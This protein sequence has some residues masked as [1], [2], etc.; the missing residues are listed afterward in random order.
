MQDFVVL[1][2]GF[3]P[4]VDLTYLLIIVVLTFKISLS[5]ASR[6]LS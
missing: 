1:A 3:N 2:T 4:D 5:S 6:E